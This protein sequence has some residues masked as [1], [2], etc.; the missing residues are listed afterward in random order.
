MVQ[1]GCLLGQSVLDNLVKFQDPRLWAFG[2][3]IPLLPL[4]LRGIGYAFSEGLIKQL[5]VLSDTEKS[6]AK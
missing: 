5:S 6:Q 4:F 1:F 3:S 2:V